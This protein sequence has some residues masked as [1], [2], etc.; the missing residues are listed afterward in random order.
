[1]ARLSQA[2]RAEI[3]SE[4]HRVIAQG[5]RYHVIPFRSRWIVVKDEGGASVRSRGVARTK[6][7]AV[8]HARALA[9]ESAGELIIHRRD[10]GIQERLSFRGDPLP[11]HD[12]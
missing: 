7:A 12:A 10:G 4:M 6:D 2:Q 11:P 8:Q 3:L 9:M 1:M 5:N